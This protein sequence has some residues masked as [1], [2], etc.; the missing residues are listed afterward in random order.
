M[1][2]LSKP[3]TD[4]G[5]Y[6]TKIVEQRENGKNKEVFNKFQEYWKY[7]CIEYVDKLGNPEQILKSPIVC[8]VFK[9]TLLNLY[10]APKV[11]NVHAES[12][13]ELRNGS[14]RICPACG[15]LSTPETLD[16]YLPKDKYPE[17]ATLP[18]NLAPMCDKCQR[19]KSSKTLDSQGLKMFIH[20]YFDHIPDNISLLKVTISE[21]FVSPKVKLTANPL[22]GTQMLPIVSRHIDHLKLDERFKKYFRG[23]FIRILRSAKRLRDMEKDVEG[24][25]KIFR[26]NASLDSIHSWDYVLYSECLNNNDLLLFLTNDELPEHI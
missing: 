13:Q 11:G 23:H 5:S 10:N 17:Y 7:L 25:F 19:E 2:K 24:N 20:P 22:I 8:E 9:N 6:I 14:I 21:P 18:E 12:I 15:N 26:E 16:H 4:I 1:I 3:Q